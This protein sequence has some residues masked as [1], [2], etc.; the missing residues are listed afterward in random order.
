MLQNC[1]VTAKFLYIHNVLLK[2]NHKLYRDF[3]ISLW[4]YHDYLEAAVA[5]WIALVAH[6]RWFVGSNP[7]RVIDGVR[8][9]IRQYAPVLQR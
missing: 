8:R 5:Q 6:G 1:M 7:I 9:G 4:V 3:D 2:Y